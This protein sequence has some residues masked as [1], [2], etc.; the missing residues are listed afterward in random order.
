MQVP[1]RPAEAV[2][3]GGV[4]QQGCFRP[5]PWPPRDGAHFL[6]LSS[7]GMVRIVCL[8]GRRSS[9]A[10]PALSSHGRQCSPGPLLCGGCQLTLG[11]QCCGW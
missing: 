11:S 4:L 8:D 6:D 9:Y 2:S 3:M 1:L 5:A 7:A 10:R